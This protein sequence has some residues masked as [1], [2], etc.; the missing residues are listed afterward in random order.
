M[1]SSVY[2]SKSTL[3]KK[4]LLCILIDD[5]S[6]IK[7]TALVII[8]KSFTISDVDNIIIMQ[9]NALLRVDT[10]ALR[11]LVVKLCSYQF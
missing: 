8:V 1:P 6:R 9:E 7:W 4:L 3:S 10:G 11:F 2:T 5:L